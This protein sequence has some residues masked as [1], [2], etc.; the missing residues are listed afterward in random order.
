MTKPDSDATGEPWLREEIVPPVAI[1]AGRGRLPRYTHQCLVQQGIDHK[2]LALDNIF[3]DHTLVVDARIRW[4]K[5]QKIGDFLRRHNIQSAVFVGK[6]YRPKL[7]DLR[8]DF[9]LAKHLVTLGLV[10]GGDDAV[11][12]KIAILFEKLFDVSIVDP[13]AL[14]HHIPLLQGTWGRHHPSAQDLEDIA[15]GHQVLKVISAADF[16]QSVIVDQG[17][18]L[19]IEAIEGTDSLIKRCFALKD[20]QPGGVLVKTLKTVQDNKLDPPVIGLETLHVAHESAL[21][22]LAIDQG[23]V[24]IDPEQVRDFANKKNMFIHII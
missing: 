9:L 19:G 4:D 1:I 14:L 20:H 7:S 2:I 10:R 23:T 6:V 5:W 21:H 3:D 18:V 15:R 8:P 17:R 22:G 11:M 13:H 16:G 24:I 12:R